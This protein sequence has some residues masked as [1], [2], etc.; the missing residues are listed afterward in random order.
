MLGLWVVAAPANFSDYRGGSGGGGWV[1][2]WEAAQPVGAGFG[3]EVGGGGRMPEGLVETAGA[4][5]GRWRQAEGDEGHVTSTDVRRALMRAREPSRVRA[6]QIT[7]MN[8]LFCHAA[9]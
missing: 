1:W 4:R 2:R 6:S 7:M 3:G 5:G 8:G 9:N